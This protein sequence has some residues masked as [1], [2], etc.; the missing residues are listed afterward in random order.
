MEKKNKPSGPTVEQRIVSDHDHCQ[1]VESLKT[2]INA[3]KRDVTML[4]ENQRQLKTDLE[5]RTSTCD[6][7]LDRFKD[8]DKKIRFYT[9]FVTYTMFMACFN[10]LSTSAA[11]MRTWQGKRTSSG[12]RTTEKTGPKPKL[13]P[14]DQ[15]FMV[16]VRLRLGLKV[17]DL[18]DRFYVSPATVSRIFIFWINLMY[19]KFKELPMWMSRSKVDKYMPPC[20]KEW[21]PSTRVIIDATEFYI[22]KPSSLTRQSATWSSYKN[23]NTFKVLVGISPDGTI[24]F[25]SNLY[26][27]SISN[28]DLVEQCGISGL[29]ENGD[30]VM[31][32]KGF[33][34]QYLLTK[35]GVRL[36]IPPF[37]RGEQQLT[38]DE[39]MKTKKIAAVHI[40]VERAIG[41]IKQYNILSGVLP[42]SLWDVSDQI[43]FV[44]AYLTNFEPGLCA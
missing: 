40:H 13:T 33:D 4:Q 2:E 3:L 8:D 31:A 39:I 43:V 37:R 11:E 17:E 12:E 41:R 36:N 7:C 14:Q 28:V 34:I 32:D 5:I 18:A 23:H 16:M 19:V 9:G 20:F 29:L 27:G 24:I 38:P 25:T 42:N 26:E 15:F 30:S 10:F 44:V 21:Y 22:E 6:F 1:C 35:L